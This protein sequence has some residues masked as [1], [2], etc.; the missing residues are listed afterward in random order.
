MTVFCAWKL[1]CPDYYQEEVLLGIFATRELADKRIAREA[2]DTDEDSIQRNE[3]KFS[4]TEEEV[5][6]Q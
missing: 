4:V 5:L 1:W 3:I 2:A 6:E